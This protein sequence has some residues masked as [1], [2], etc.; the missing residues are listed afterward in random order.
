[1]LGMALRP[2]PELAL[3][4]ARA[5]AARHPI[6]I[7]RRRKAPRVGS[8]KNLK[9][10]ETPSEGIFDTFEGSPPRAF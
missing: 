6:D 4:A 2:T 8:L 10:G 9:I 5:S 1:M 7:E 3:I